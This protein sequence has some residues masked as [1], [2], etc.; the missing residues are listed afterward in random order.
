MRGNK[1][2]TVEKEGWGIYNREASY[3]VGDF[4]TRRTDAITAL[5]REERRPWSQIKHDGKFVPVK[6]RI[7]LDQSEI[8]NTIQ[9]FKVCGLNLIWGQEM[10]TLDFDRLAERSI[11]K[12]P[13]LCQLIIKNQEGIYIWHTSN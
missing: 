7:T 9:Q 4:F 13:S 12:I 5:E 6:I 11:L 3:L 2:V 8:G 1:I 10:D